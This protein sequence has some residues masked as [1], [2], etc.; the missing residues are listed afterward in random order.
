[1]RT[2][3]QPRGQDPA[4]PFWTQ[5]PERHMRLKRFSSGAFATLLKTLFANRNH[6]P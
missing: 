4:E 2:D 5:A 1:M 3:S 6:I